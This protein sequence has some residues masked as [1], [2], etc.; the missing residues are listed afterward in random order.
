[1]KN[2]NV[3]WSGPIWS[4]S[5]DLAGEKIEVNAVGWFEI[6][7][8]R[9]LWNSVPDYSS[10]SGTNE[11][12]IALGLLSVANSDR[13]TWITAGT[14]SSTSLRK[15]KYE[16]WQS[17]GEEIINLSDQEDGFDI[18]V[19][20]ETRKL[21]LVDADQYVNRT[22]IPFGMNWGPD[23]IS[24]IVIE[25]NG[26]EMRNRIQ[27]VGAN[28]NVWQYDADG[29]DGKP[30]TQ[31]SHNLMTEIIQVTEKDDATVLQAIA[32]AQ[33]A[34]KQYPV[35]NYDIQLKAQGPGNPYSIFE[36]YNIGDRI[37]VTANKQLGSE[38]IQLTHEPRIFGAT[39]NIDDNGI[40][41]VSSLQT[42]FSGS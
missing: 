24:N 2:N 30:D 31:A 28:N 1:M 21:N 32:N 22:A 39:I 27:V 10:G 3:V 15:V 29:T 19:D 9:F 41:R 8:N 26:G 37:Y 34:I 36:D 7:M 5:I 4:R 13:Q 6:L 14:N 35:M 16:I 23:N 17:V 33:G 38:T 12:T 18:Y 25:E 40:E 42:T 11:G 20:P